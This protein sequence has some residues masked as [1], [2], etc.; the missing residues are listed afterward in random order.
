LAA[1]ALGNSL[2]AFQSENPSHSYPLG[3]PAISSTQWEDFQIQS[4]ALRTVE[5]SSRAVELAQSGTPEPEPSQNNLESTSYVVQ[6]HF[7]PEEV[8]QP[9]ILSPI[10]NS[11]TIAGFGVP[12]NKPSVANSPET[13]FKTSDYSQL[14]TLQTASPAVMSNQTSAPNEQAR[15]PEPI[16]GPTEK[17]MSAMASEGQ[18]SEIRRDEIKEASQPIP[19][20]TPS[21]PTYEG[22]LWKGATVQISNTGSC[23]NART[24]PDG[25]SVNACLPENFVVSIAEGPEQANGRWWWRLEG[26]GWSADEYLLV[27][28]GSRPAVSYSGFTWPKSGSITDQFGVLRSP[29]NYHKGVDIGMHKGTSRVQVGAAA[30]G[31]AIVGDHGTTSYGRFIIIDHG[32]GYQS[33]YAHLSRVAVRAGQYVYQGETIGYTGCTGQCYGEHLHF[34]IRKNGTPVNPLNHLP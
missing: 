4:N 24:E 33:L 26:Y 27:Y 7:E 5:E 10:G 20:P 16:Y 29:G 14:P 8:E 21:A 15:P 3:G 18:G 12:T 9:Q 17:L 22:K 32:N 11:N 13:A 19:E 2:P 28:D 31:R 6:L 34:E 30:S 1:L 23:L 25:A